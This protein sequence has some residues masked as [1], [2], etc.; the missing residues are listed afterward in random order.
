[1]SDA[2]VPF[3]VSVGDRDLEDLRDRLR[4]TRWADEELVNDWSQGVPR[5]YLQRV[6]RYWAEQYD[7]RRFESRLNAIP[8]FRTEI[9]GVDVHFL[10]VRSTHAD[11]LPLVITHGWPGSIVE[12][13]DVIG[14]L[15]DPV[16]QGGRLADAFDVVI[17]SLPGFGFS[18]K[19]TTLGWNRERVADA[20]AILMAR[21]GYPRFAA[22]GGDWGASVANH[23]AQRHPERTIGIHLN[24]VSV[25]P[26]PGAGEPGA[27]EHYAAWRTARG[28]RERW[29]SG[30]MHQQ[31]TRPQT[32]GYGLSDS[33]AGQCAWILEKFKA[34]SDCG[35][36]PVSAFGI[37]RLL[38]NISLYWLTN[39]STSSARFYWECQPGTFN[40]R[41]EV[42]MGATIYPKEINRPP[43]T[44]AERVYAD[45]RYWHEVDRGGHFA[46][47]EHPDLFVEEIRACFQEL[48]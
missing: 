47:F 48:R 6:C 41:V 3:E 4:R 32:L 1:M 44:W 12:F 27:D 31:R 9:H 23:L 20:W 43:R 10:H 34:W 33:P 19:P 38:D 35:D 5:V 37:D 17:P 14:P 2:I 21:L 25:D 26:P 13:L 46:A 36:D 24:L 15:T 30:Y 29:E 40:G 16:A 42:P 7:W 8:Q 39:T 28:H 45:L 11:A 22:Q 18:S